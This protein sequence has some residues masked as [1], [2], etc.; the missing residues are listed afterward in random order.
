MVKP[1]DSSR[2][3]SS[4]RYQIIKRRLQ[5]DGAR[6]IA[7]GVSVTALQRSPFVLELVGLM[8]PFA[9]GHAQARMADQRASLGNALADDLVRGIRCGDFGSRRRGCARKPPID[10]AVVNGFTRLSF[11]VQGR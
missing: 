3:C 11:T 7:A 2:E 6:S 10:E 4:L 5:P 8:L 9:R 1:F